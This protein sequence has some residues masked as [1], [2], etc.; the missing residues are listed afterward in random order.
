MVADMETLTLLGAGYDD[1]SNIQG[2]EY[3]TNLTTLR[4]HSNQISDISPVAGLTNLTTLSLYSNQI[5]DISALAGLTNM[6]C[7]VLESNEI[8]DISPITGLMNRRELYLGQN[9]IE[10][11][12]FS[13]TDLS[14][15]FRFNIDGNPLV[16][17]LLVDATFSQVA[18]GAIMEGAYLT[19]Y[20]TYR[21]MSCSG[22][23]GLP[24][25]LNLDMSGV[26]FG[27]ISD[28]SSM[29]GA[30][31]L[32]TLLL[33]GATNLD[34]GEVVTLTGELDSLDW[35]DVTGLWGSFEPAAQG[36]LR[37]WDAVEGNTLVIPEPATPSLLLALAAAGLFVRGRRRRFF[38]ESRG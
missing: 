3:G 36:S 1:I 16:N 5:S 19:R 27:E 22:I 33:A 2:I 10:T 38:A 12:D 35:L 7:L 6:D 11:M 23:A 14:S 4:L 32:E 9:Q 26:D 25:V 8:S 28:L 18:F 15:L 21:F 30:D 17:V 29:Y 24:G 34:G 31:D 20:S 13:G 37:A